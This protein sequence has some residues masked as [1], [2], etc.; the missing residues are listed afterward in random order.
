M[1]ETN[2][3]VM[4]MVRRELEKDPSVGN[5]KLQE[6]AARIDPSLAQLTTRQFHAKYPL[7]VKRA[8]KRGGGSSAAAK[9][10]GRARKATKRSAGSARKGTKR[11]RRSAAGGRAR[12]AASTPAPANG[13]R[14]RKAAGEGA[15][16][17]RAGGRRQAAA[18][19]AASGREG[20]RAVLLD[21]ARQVAAA[22]ERADLIDVV[23]AVD[24]WVD[25]I[26]EQTA[27]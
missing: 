20:V 4:E 23:S 8:K 12:Q 27:G 25:R 11:G 13:R 26:M 22:N 1:A 19:A 24:G 17:R 5:E 2:E 18:P 14:R 21:F 15:R 7:Q 10:G 9:R 6:K 3:R 16:K